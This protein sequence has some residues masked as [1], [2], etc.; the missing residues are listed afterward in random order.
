ML[1]KSREELFSFG[2]IIAK[3]NFQVLGYI[4]IYWTNWLCLIS[5]FS[6]Y[7]L[8]NLV[9][10]F[11]KES[12]FL[13]IRPDSLIK[14]Y[15]WTQDITKQFLYFFMYSSLALNLLISG[16]KEVFLL[17]SYCVLRTCLKFFTNSNLLEPLEELGSG[18]AV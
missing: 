2:F 7:R 5:M 8:W 18:F 6:P 16:L 4:L 14:R 11:R 17:E 10:H 13:A 15:V 9:E 3:W 1:F 12:F